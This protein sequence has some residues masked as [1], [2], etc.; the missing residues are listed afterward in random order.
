MARKPRDVPRELPLLRLLPNLVSILALC[1]GLTA[2]RFALAGQFGMAVLLIGGAAALDGLDGRLARMLKSESAIGAEL[3]SLCDLV[4]F[5]V[6]P[7]LVL[8]LWGL[9]AETEFGWI[10]VLVYAV[11]C[12]LRLARF[13]VGSKAPGDAAEKTSFIGVP[14]PAGAMLALVPIYLVFAFHGSFQLPPAIIALWMVGVGVLMISRT[15]TPSL[16]RITIAT[17]NARYV[18]VGA[19]VVVAALLTYPWVTLL[20]LSLGY[21]AAILLLFLR[22]L[23]KAPVV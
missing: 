18:L 4:N 3:D 1:S 12:M 21:L 22:S 17:E 20:T 11:C 5:G 8:Y 9:R 2:I 6:T 7:A 16:K 13:N 15:R 23:R 10:A 14:S 19:V